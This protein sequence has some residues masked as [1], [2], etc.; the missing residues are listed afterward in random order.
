M[1]AFLYHAKNV[2]K[3]KS[4]SLIACRNLISIKFRAKLL[5]VG[6]V[7]CEPMGLLPGKW[8]FV[9]TNDG[10]PR[11]LIL[12]REEKILKKHPPELQESDQDATKY[13]QKLID[14]RGRANL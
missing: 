9:R 13:I 3:F 11:N 5:L 12:D 2:Q 14:I 7:L 10:A 1:I 8:C 4:E 6:P